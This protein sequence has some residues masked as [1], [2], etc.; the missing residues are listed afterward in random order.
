MLDAPEN[1]E[2]A[3]ILA[4]SLAVFFTERG[5]EIRL[6]AGE[7]EITYDAAGSHLW[8]ACSFSH[9]QALRGYD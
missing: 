9:V 2:K 5:Y 8:D 6:V 1:F 4:A 7:Q 3:V